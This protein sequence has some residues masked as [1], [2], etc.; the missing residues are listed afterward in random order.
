MDLNGRV[1]QLSTFISN[2]S[3]EDQQALSQLRELVDSFFAA[4]QKIVR[5]AAHQ[6]I[7]PVAINR[8]SNITRGLQGFDVD[9]IDR[10]LVI[11]PIPVIAARPGDP[12]HR[13][14]FGR[15]VIFHY[16]LADKPPK[17]T[18]LYEIL[19]APKRTWEA[20]GPI[21]PWSGVAFEVEHFENFAM[22]VIENVTYRTFNTH[23]T[24]AESRLS[25]SPQVKPIGF[26]LEQSSTS[27]VDAHADPS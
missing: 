25:P 19:S 23:N 20:S 4:F 3:K 10:R 18:P 21:T 2:W 11:Q 8:H 13:T 7:N 24:L 12:L 17:E 9:W 16:F 26:S 15:V 22:M 5:E 14:L 1:A 27:G 6:G